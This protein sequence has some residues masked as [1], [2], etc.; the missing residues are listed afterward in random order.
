MYKKS[1]FGLFLLLAT[2]GAQAIDFGVGVKAGINGVGLDLSINSAYRENVVIDNGD[3]VLGGVNRGDN[4]CSGTGA[5][6]SFC[7]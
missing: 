7:P 2:T 6:S 5:S 4:Y 3:A 1:F